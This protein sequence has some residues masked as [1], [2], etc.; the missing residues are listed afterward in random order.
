MKAYSTA[1]AAKVSGISKMTLHRWILSGRIR[2][3]RLTTIAGVKVRLWTRK[4]V[5]H[6]RRVVAR[7]RYKRV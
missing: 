5:E 7:W 1:G 6:L 3:P 2:P 4:D